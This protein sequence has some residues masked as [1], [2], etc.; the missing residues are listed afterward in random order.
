MKL[1]N[2]YPRPACPSISSAVRATQPLISTTC[3]VSLFTRFAIPERSYTCRQY[4]G[5]AGEEIV[6][7]EPCR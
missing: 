2:E 1:S 6:R 4:E 3:Q 7:H 5:P